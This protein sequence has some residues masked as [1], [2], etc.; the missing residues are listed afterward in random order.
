MFPLTLKNKCSL[1]SKDNKEPKVKELNFQNLKSYKIGDPEPNGS[2]YRQVPIDVSRILGSWNTQPNPQYKLTN[3]VVAKGGHAS[4]YEVIDLKD[5][6]NKLIAKVLKNVDDLPKTICLSSEDLH[7]LEATIYYTLDK[8]GIV[9]KLYDIYT[10]KDS[11]VIV[12]QRYDKSL[13]SFDPDTFD[14]EPINEKEYKRAKELIDKMHSV[15]II[16]MDS[17][18]GNIVIRESDNDMKLIDFGSAIFS[19]D[20]ELRKLDDENLRST[21]ETIGNRPQITFTVNGVP[22]DDWN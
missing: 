13:R 15:G 1:L 22:C 11:L 5:P 16:H 12:S 9:P 4:T 19:D 20:E 21:L 8:I 14:S 7:N 17:H 3:N 2:E 10:T 6:N 18:P